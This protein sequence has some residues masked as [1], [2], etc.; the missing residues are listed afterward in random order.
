MAPAFPDGAGLYAP[1]FDAESLADT[2][3]QVLQNEAA[4]RPRRRFLETGGRKNFFQH[5]LDSFPPP[6]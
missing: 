5:C 3:H 6:V 4:F 2:F 1:E